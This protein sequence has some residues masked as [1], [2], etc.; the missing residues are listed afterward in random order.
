MKKQ[1]IHIALIAA[2][3]GVTTAQAS[4]F[5]G[6]WV[7]AK[8]GKNRASATGLDSQTPT[9][10]GLEGGYNWNMG[11]YLLGVD[12]FAD[13]NKRATHAPGAI[14]YGSHVYGL[15]AKLGIPYGNWLPYAKLGYANTSGNGDVVLRNI[16]DNDVHLGLGVE[17]KFAPNWSLTGEV[18]NS[19]GESGVNKLRNT[20]ATIGLN[21]Y[22]GGAKAAA[23]TAAANELQRAEYQATPA[24]PAVLEQATYDLEPAL[25][26]SAPEAATLTR[27]TWETLLQEKALVIEGAHFDFDSAKLRPT[28]DAKLNEVVEFAAAYPDA[29][30]EVSGY[31]DSIG[32]E[33]YNLKL[34]ER[35]AAAVKQYLVNKGVSDSRIHTQGYGEADP[36]ASNKTKEGRAKNRRVE[37]RS[38]GVDETTIRV[39]N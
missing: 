26:Q 12:G 5:D 29:K 30:L 4:E 10:Y 14:N 7:G 38:L 31:T 37:L 27:E 28:A 20:N 25:K 24:A 21:F 2:L 17:Y 23:P 34:S 36:V 33:K 1:S 39:I 32:A 11:N 16:D 3:F 6:G 13:I 19:S 18:T 15:D 22:F 35:R 9:S 8:I